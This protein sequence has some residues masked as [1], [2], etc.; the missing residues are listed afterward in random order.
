MTRMNFLKGCLWL[1]FQYGLLATLMAQNTEGT[2]QVR[3][4]HPA[5]FYDEVFSLTLDA[6][7]PAY[8]IIY[9]IDGSNPQNS[10]TAKN[11]GKSLA[12]NINPNSANGRATTPCFL[13]RASL[14][15]AGKETMLPVSR[16]YI[17]PEAVIN[18]RHPGG[19]WP[20]SNV[21]DQIIDLEMDP[22]VTQHFSYQHRIE[23]ALKAI[24]SISVVTDLKNL[25]DPATGIYVNAQGHGDEWERFCSVELIDPK[26]QSEFNIN[27]GLRIRGGWSRHGNYPKHAFR[28]F[29]RSEYGMPKLYFPL[30]G[31]EGVNEFDKID[32]RTAQNYAW[33]NGQDHNTFVREVFSR[34]T[35]RDM[36][37]PYTRSRYYHLYL[38]GMYWG[39]FQTQERS[40]ARFASDYFGGN[41]EDYD[42]VKVDT[43]NYTYNMEATDGNLDGWEKLWN[44][45]KA[46]FSNN[47]NY[48]KLEGKDRNGLPEPGKETLVDIDNL[49]DYMLTIFYGGNF[50]APTSA[51]RGNR[52]PNNFYTIYK[53]DDKSQGFRFFNHDAEHSLMI[54]PV[55]PGIGIN[56]NRVDLPSMYVDNMYKFHPQWLHQKLTEN[57]EYRQR[58][59]DRV[60]RHFFNDGV[61]TPEKAEER[62][63]KR[64]M[65]IDEAIIAESAR[66]GDTFRGEAHTRDN[67]WWPEIENMQYY[68]FPYRT[69]IVIEQFIEADLFTYHAPPRFAVDGVNLNA[70]TKLF[71]EHA[72]V[73][74]S[75]LNSSGEIYLT[76]D[77]SDPRMV[78]GAVSDKAQKIN[79][80]T[81]FNIRGTHWFKA[82]VKIGNEWSPLREVR[83]V[84]NWEDFLNLK[85][86]ELHYHPKD[87]IIGTD[88]VSGKSFEFIEIKNIGTHAVDL[89]RVEFT[90]GID[91]RFKAGTMLAPGQFVVLAASSKWFFE[92]YGKAAS[93][94]YKGSFDNDGEAVSIFSTDKRKIAQFGYSPLDPWPA[95]TS[96]TGH[97]LT[98][99]GVYPTGDPNDPAYW[100]V[101]TF[102]DGSPFYDDLGW[103]LASDENLSTATNWMLYPNPT[104]GILTL[105]AS[106][107]V[108][109]EYEVFNSLGKKMLEGSYWGS[110]SIDLRTT[111]IPAGLILVKMKSKGETKVQKIHYRP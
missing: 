105:M 85:V 35:Q 56:E 95:G 16:T 70:S 77:G 39:L 10:S 94:V 76:T 65:E 14:K 41:K 68:F 78:G 47:T 82:R 99:I 109:F 66:W 2:P 111:A 1:V 5:G 52:D 12:I 15:E 8:D 61:F 43:E 7:A 6:P 59:A 89:S 102:M 84:K 29:F 60:Y 51:F 104:N 30:F 91:Y 46:G 97:S 32:L 3:F 34:D 88:T 96:E 100:K 92:R 23:D 22:K 55:N 110:G 19:A 42:V 75:N 38:N 53:R 71:N 25:F 54:D 26:R 50:D 44:A 21:N 17:F 73:V 20:T 37:Q 79:T 62:F 48:F 33:S 36:G 69:D 24:P 90:S 18:Q 107:D 86:T 103:K 64:A 13:V 9:T 40:E 93:D 57:A 74:L 67:D 106:T 108:F 45:T 81:E 28:L 27:A 83:L 63:M 4:S 58:F 87:S 31:N 11:G 98:A 80:G 101:S 49:I 72:S